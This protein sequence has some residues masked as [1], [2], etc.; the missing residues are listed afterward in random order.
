MIASQWGK[1]P[2]ESVQDECRQRGTKEVVSR[3]VEILRGERIDEATLRA[4]A[5][6]A[7][8]PVLQGREGGVDGYWPRVWAMRGLLYAWNETAIEVVCAGASDEHWRVRE[9]SAKVVAR[10]QVADAFDAMEELKG[11][12][13]SRVRDAADRALS[14]LADFGV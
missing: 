1:T 2:R 7:A 12:H 5:G 8:E 13:V 9:M 11:D 6:P 4:L 14:R 10:H 3:C